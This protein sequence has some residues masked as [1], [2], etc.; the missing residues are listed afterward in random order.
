MS[1]VDIEYQ[2][3][4]PVFILSP[5]FQYFSDIRQIKQYLEIESINISKEIII[6]LSHFFR[7]DAILL[8]HLSELIN[9]FR[10]RVKRF[11]V[12]IPKEVALEGLKI[13]LIDDFIE[14]YETKYEAVYD[15]LN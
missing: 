14:I 13:K 6:D 15:L 2:E 1:D 8:N 12:V 11:G 5:S 3:R 10:N 9:E 4:I 7:V